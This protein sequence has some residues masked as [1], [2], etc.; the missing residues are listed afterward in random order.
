MDII[1]FTLHRSKMTTAHMKKH[2]R[3]GLKNRKEGFDPHFFSLLKSLPFSSI[4]LS[5]YSPLAHILRPSH[6]GQAQTVYTVSHFSSAPLI[7]CKISRKR[8]MI[9][10]S[11]TTSVRCNYVSI[12]HRKVIEPQ[13][14][15]TSLRTY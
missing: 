9:F 10:Y 7:K 12:I 1:Y 6:L 14:D 2:A 15:K 4:P 11:E 5:L 13:R 3:G 8:N